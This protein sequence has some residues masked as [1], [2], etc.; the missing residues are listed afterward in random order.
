MTA[1]KLK[2]IE[3][4]RKR[5]AMYVGSMNFHGV[6]TML[7]YFIEDILDVSNSKI[8]IN[9]EIKS[10]NSIAVIIENIDATLL[11]ES[12][13]YL[14]E[15]NNYKSLALPVIIALSKKVN[16]K[17]TNN[18]TF[19]SLTSS[20]G[21]F[22]IN[23]KKIT[24]KTNTIEIEFQ[25]DKSFF[26][27]TEL[28]YEALNQFLKKYA[29]LNS[30]CRMISIDSRKNIQQTILFDYPKGLSQQLDL[31]LAQQQFV[32]SFFRLD[33]LTKLDNYEYQICFSY[34]NLWDCKTTIQTF[35]NYDEL[36][37]G[38]SLEKGILDGLFL[39]LK[40]IANKMKIK[41]DKRKLK[42]Q[43]ILLAVIKGDNIYFCGPTK[44]KIDFPKVRKN[45]KQFVCDKTLK[46]LSENE[47]IEKQ[48][49]NKLEK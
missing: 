4:I 13:N 19:I 46:Y 29:F 17:I 35:A 10:N 16:L 33:L 5:P 12:V 11:L 49:L 43:L 39:A 1:Q 32:H 30:N 8:D 26:K 38:G 48:L 25:I 40:Q 15:E 22:L 2:I 23:T 37:Y 9:I 27:E 18:S 47:Q 28:N 42:E 21:N 36:I 41:F 34:Q 6:K 31:I 24:P 3:H 44:T 45:V 20:N 7:G 14:T